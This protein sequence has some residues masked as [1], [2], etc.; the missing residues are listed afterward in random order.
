[1][2]LSV[3]WAW[4]CHQR[5]HWSRSASRRLSCTS[6]SD[7]IGCQL[8]PRRAEAQI[9][10]VT[11][12]RTTLARSKNGALARLRRG[13][14]SSAGSARTKLRDVE[15]GHLQWS[16]IGAGA[17]RSKTALSGADKNAWCHDQAKHANFAFE[18]SASLELQE[19]TLKRGLRT[20]AR[21]LPKQNPTVQSKILQFHFGLD[22]ASASSSLRIW[23]APPQ[24]RFWC[25]FPLPNSGS[26]RSESVLTSRDQSKNLLVYFAFV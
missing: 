14:V 20:P 12:V 26:H 16:E 8:Q 9:L 25:G 7:R 11:L 18:G 19:S 22:F 5:L 24:F 6:H 1:M 10:A 23:R 4:E 3:N 17:S 2:G 13:L 21:V 15:L